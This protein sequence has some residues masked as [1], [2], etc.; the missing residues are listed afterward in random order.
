MDH[1]RFLSIVAQAAGIDR[2]QAE[3]AVRA[4]LQTLGER[5]S[6]GEARDLA[7]QLPPEAAPW[8]ATTGPAEPFDR[9]ELLR[10]VAAREGVDLETAERHVRAVLDALAQAVSGS[11]LS[12]L[13]AQLPADFAPL[14]PVG[15]EVDVMPANDFVRRVAER[16]GVDAEHARRATEAVLET[17]AERIAGGVVRDLEERLPIELRWPLAR[18]VER[19]AGRATRLGLSEFLARV[20][21][22]TGQTPAQ[23]RE[24]V[25]AVLSVLRE[26]VGD[27]EYFDVINQLPQDYAPVLP[28][29]AR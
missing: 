20:A 5:I 9:A 21:V 18:G 17:L 28:A 10:R 26:A 22:R 15:R 1:E 14:L 16:A 4:A 19:T 24:D 29:L 23:A 27:R 13:T 25:R 3:G 11:E 8:L 6:A 12:D 2:D 7:E